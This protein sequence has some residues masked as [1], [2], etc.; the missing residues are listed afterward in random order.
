MQDCQH[1]CPAGLHQQRLS[2][3]A[4]SFP[5]A[6]GL[7]LEEGLLCHRQQCRSCPKVVLVACHLHCDTERDCLCM[8]AEGYPS[9]E[10]TALP[11][12]RLTA[13]SHAEPSFSPRGPSIANGSLGHPGEL[14]LP[15]GDDLLGMT[16]HT[17]AG[18]S[19][20]SR[21]LFHFK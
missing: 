15:E 14:Q 13:G 16:A 11:P 20:V 21:C 3:R 18:V 2:F 4:V 9:T 8:L 12:V 10:A 5:A 7:F 17:P 6:E 1:N 19:Q